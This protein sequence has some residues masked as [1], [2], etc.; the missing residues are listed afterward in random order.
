M[1]YR[2]LSTMQS[3]SQEKNQCKYPARDATVGADWQR[4]KVGKVG[5]V[6]GPKG[7][8]KVNKNRNDPKIL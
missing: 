1:G 6:E 7:L 2:N 3:A 8:K 4:G 5:K